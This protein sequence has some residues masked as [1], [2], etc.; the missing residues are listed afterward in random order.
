[1]LR[2]SLAGAPP[3]SF[4]PTRWLRCFH[5]DPQTGRY[6]LAVMNAVR[7]VALATLAGL[8]IFVLARRRSGRRNGSGQGHGQA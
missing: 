2:A 6:S 4:D 1:M 3:A 5:Y 7:L 8:G